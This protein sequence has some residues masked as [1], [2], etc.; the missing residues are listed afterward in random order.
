LAKEKL[1]L[2]DQ[3]ILL[4]DIEWRPV[5][6]FVWRAW[7]ENISPEQIIED[8]GLLCVGAKWLGDK[9]TELF[10]EWDHGHI[11]MLKNIY[12]MLAIADVVITYNGDKYD[13]PKLDGEF[14]RYNLPPRPPCTS[15]DCIKQIKKFGFFRSSLAFIGPFLGLGSKLEHE[16]FGL[17]KKVMSGDGNAQKRMAKYCIQD[18]RLLERLYLRIR[19]HIKTHPHMGR[20]GREQC[21]SCGSSHAQSRGSRRTRAFK[22]SRLHCTDC[23][24][25]FDGVR[26]KI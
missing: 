20:T 9:D 18:V 3:K 10:S 25:W 24:H 15:I 8:G 11:G 16:G 7:D 26:S 13:L 4:L 14:V 17:W 12:E 19:A 5:R 22:I 23:G 21:P 1:V 6:A 2:P